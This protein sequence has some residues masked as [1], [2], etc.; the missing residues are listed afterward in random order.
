[1]NTTIPADIYQNVLGECV[2]K[3]MNEQINNIGRN[4]FSF[5]EA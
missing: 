4:L 1:M 5:N 3:L 2:N